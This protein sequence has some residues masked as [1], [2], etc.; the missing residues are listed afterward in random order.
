MWFSVGY[1]PA[2]TIIS[3]ELYRLKAICNFHLALNKLLYLI[4]TL[5]AFSSLTVQS[6]RTRKVY[7]LQILFGSDNDCFLFC[8]TGQSHHFGMPLL[9]IDYNL[10]VCIYHFIIGMLNPVLEF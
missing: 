8:L 6:Y 1:L 5:R 3:I 9:S 7:L 2:N 4:K 10:P